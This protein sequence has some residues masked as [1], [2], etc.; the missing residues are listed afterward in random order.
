MI[1]VT[2]KFI[3]IQNYIKLSTRQL[4]NYQTTS[5]FQRRRIQYQK[6]TSLDTHEEAYETTIVTCMV[7][8]TKPLG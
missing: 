5:H 6:S 8:Q 2:R 1:K 3:K 7:E 4:R